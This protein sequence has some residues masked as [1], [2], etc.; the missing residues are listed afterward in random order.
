MPIYEYECESCGKVIE[1]WQKFSD[2]PLGTCES[3]GGNLHKLISHSSFHLKGSG[4]YVTDYAGKKTGIA[5][6]KKS[7]PSPDKKSKKD[8]ASS[9]GSPSS[10]SSDPTP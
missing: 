9:S 5:D 8:S 7:E 6:T 2:A 1:N 10:S 3:C 4:W